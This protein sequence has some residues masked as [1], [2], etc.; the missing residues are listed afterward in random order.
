[1]TETRKVAKSTIQIENERVI[2]TEWRFEP[3]AET[4]W[5]CHEH[6]YIVVPQTTG[7]LLIETENGEDLSEVTFGISYA[8][9]S[10]SK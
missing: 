3:R 4:T 5:H 8:Q 2:V 10:Q 7:N 6:D 1:M 9:R